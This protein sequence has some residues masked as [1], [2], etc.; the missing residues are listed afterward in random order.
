MIVRKEYNPQQLPDSTWA[1]PEVAVLREGKQ[2]VEIPS[3]EHL[4]PGREMMQVLLSRTP[5]WHMSLR[6]ISDDKP[7]QQLKV[8]LSDRL[9]D[10]GLYT[11]SAKSCPVFHFEEASIRIQPD[12]A[13]ELG[14]VMID[15]LSKHVYSC[16]A[17]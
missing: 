17:A 2:C 4:H 8:V 3:A 9:E 7:E 11:P 15:Q 16:E 6:I 12:A 13:G 14:D 10:D 5:S 1:L